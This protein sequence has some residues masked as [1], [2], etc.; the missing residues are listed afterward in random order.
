MD[1]LN[2]S[3]LIKFL[4]N[5]L[6]V[7]VLGLAGLMFGA[8][9]MYQLFTPHQTTDI[10]IQSESNS[11]GVKGASD[12]KTAVFIDIEGAVKRPG[13][14]E[15][16]NDRRLK[17][18]VIKAGGLAK[19]VNMTYVSKSL[20]MAA[21][22]QDGMKIYIPFQGENTAA[23]QTPAA[24]VTS[25]DT[26]SGLININTASE[27]ELDKLPGVGPATAAKIASF[28]PYASFDELVNKKAV[29]AA[30]FSKIKDKISL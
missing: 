23:L 30:V 24:P 4:K 6:L 7:I 3:P 9:G 10:L 14:Y 21:K 11:S 18:V 26:V 27:S 19:D 22:I 2:E 13:V 8:I 16:E 29:G 25:V 5:N 12:K 1:E 28:R 20:N 17:D 15:L